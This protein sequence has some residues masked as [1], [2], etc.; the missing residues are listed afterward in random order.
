MRVGNGVINCGEALDRLTQNFMRSAVAMQL[1]PVP[2]LVLVDSLDAEHL[3]V[4]VYGA[5]GIISSFY[6]FS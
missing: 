3:Q 4:S 6:D 5:L 1:S 2:L